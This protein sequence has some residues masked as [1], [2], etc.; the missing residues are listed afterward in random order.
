[1]LTNT[2]IS[3]LKA[4]HV[5]SLSWLAEATNASVTGLK[6]GSKTL[7]FTPTQRPTALR[8]GNIKIKAATAAASAP[9][10][11]QAILPYLLFA[12][13]VN[14]GDKSEDVETS[15]TKAAPLEV[16]I[17]GG[18]N[19]NWS[20]SYEYLDQVTLPLL[21]SC[22]GIHIE[23]KLN[24][25]GW[26]TGLP[27]AHGSMSFS[28]TPL[29]PGQALQH[30]G[31]KVLPTPPTELSMNEIDMTFITPAD[32]HADLQSCLTAD[33]ETLFPKVKVKLVHTEDSRHDTRMYVL[34][35]ARCR[36]GPWRWARDILYQGSRKAKAKEDLARNIS[37]RVTKDLF[38]EVQKGGVV[39]ECCQDQL[40]VFQALA[41]GVTSFPAKSKDV[42]DGLAEAMQRMNLRDGEANAEALRR[43]KTQEPFGEGSLHA[44]TARWVAAEL[45]P[46]AVWYRKGTVCRGA[47]FQVEAP[48]PV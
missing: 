40:V 16:T 6:V 29:A 45:L 23:R 30:I 46:K 28:I 2:R 47:G 10:I 21:E 24:K 25:R 22:F 38:T 15:N 3:G 20:M 5:A 36:E 34:L 14:K 31:S 12:G 7:D 19:V 33:L 32:M 48:V 13:G 43:D 18:T 26:A 44:A 11:F 9:L 17:E 1:L 27:S 41:A 42:Q 4:Q 8:D 39:D 35:V 37:R